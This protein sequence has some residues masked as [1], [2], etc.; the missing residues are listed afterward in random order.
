MP[1]ILITGANGQLG[2]ELRR[3][4]IDNPFHWTF[5]D[6]EDLDITQA[7]LVEQII[8]AGRYDFCLNTAA[9]TAVDKAESDVERA[10]QINVDG[11]RNL[12]AACHKHGCQLIHISTDFVFGGQGGKPFTEEDATSPDSVYARTKREGEQ[13]ALQAD[14]NTLI[15]RTAWLFSSF[16]SNFVKT[17]LRL[18]RERE[19]VSVVNDQI[20]C[21]TYAADLAAL[22]VRYLHECE[23][24]HPA[25]SGIYHF[26]NEGVA[27]W[28][29]L[30]HAVFEMAHLPARLLPI[31]TTAFPTPARRPSFSVLNKEKIKGT[32]NLPIRHWREALAECLKRIE[33]QEGK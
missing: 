10:Q 31:P 25:L 17:M 19:V 9:Y 30:V 27:S 26:T 1:K 4:S 12:A 28:Y 21:P 5:T 14:P 18:G 33:E 32:L 15:I 23:N 29:D 11:V 22:M 2:H 20:G 6:V 16:G 24:G 13:A 8:S 7:T 3:L